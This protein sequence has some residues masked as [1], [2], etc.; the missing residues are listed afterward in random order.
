M[1]IDLMGIFVVMYLEKLLVLILVV[2]IFDRMME[3]E[4]FELINFVKLVIFVFGF[5][6]GMRNLFIVLLGWYYGV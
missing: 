2:Y 4:D 6:F 1:F 3:D 5:G